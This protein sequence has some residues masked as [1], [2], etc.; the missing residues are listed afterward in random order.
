MYD[1]GMVGR[2][3]VACHSARWHNTC[4]GIVGSKCHANLGTTL[5]IAQKYTD[6]KKEY[7]NGLDMLRHTC[8]ATNANKQVM[9]AKT[10]I[11]RMSQAVKLDKEQQQQSKCMAGA[12]QQL[13]QCP[14]NS[15][16]RDNARWGV[17]ASLEQ[18]MNITH[19]ALEEHLY[20]HAKL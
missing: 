1:V 9:I 10:N 18:S 12:Y 3:T 5:E 16:D 14:N 13:E 2:S 11:Q 7:Q 6:V 15:V 17:L 19:N 8:K 4:A 20:G